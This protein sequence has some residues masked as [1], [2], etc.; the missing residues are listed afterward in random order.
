MRKIAL[1]L[2]LV[3]MSSCCCQVM[4]YPRNYIISEKVEKADLIVEK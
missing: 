2:I 4:P 1:F 3:S